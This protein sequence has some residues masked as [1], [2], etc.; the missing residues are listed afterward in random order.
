MKIY[1]PSCHKQTIEIEP[2][3]HGDNVRSC[4]ECQALTTVHAACYF[5]NGY[6]VAL[7]LAEGQKPSTNIS[8]VAETAPAQIGEAPTS[9]C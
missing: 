7:K 5:Y 3:D 4:P 6:M 1:C 8:M 2:R 9:P